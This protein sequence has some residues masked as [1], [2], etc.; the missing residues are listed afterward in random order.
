[1]N[2]ISLDK[3]LE[4]IGQDSLSEPDVAETVLR[5]VVGVTMD[6]LLVEDSNIERL[7]ESLDIDVDTAS[8]MTYGE[9]AVRIHDLWEH[10]ET[11]RDSVVN[12]LYM[13]VRPYIAEQRKG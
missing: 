5:S 1:M 6:D 13:L 4:R 9:V 3:R 12:A 2:R 7:A 8:A 11:Q 10:G